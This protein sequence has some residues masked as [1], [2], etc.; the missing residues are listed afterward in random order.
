MSHYA[1]CGLSQEHLRELVTEL[2]PQWRNDASLDAASGAGGGLEMPICGLRERRLPAAE[3][4]S[5]P[6]VRPRGLVL[7]KD[8][9]SPVEDMNDHLA[10]APARIRTVLIVMMQEGRALT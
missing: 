5:T 6:F 3:P 9:I 8:L 7:P 2:A 1:S 4:E 10:S